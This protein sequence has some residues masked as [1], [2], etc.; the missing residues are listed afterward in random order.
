MNSGY[1]SWQ[2]AHQPTEADLSLFGEDGNMLTGADLDQAYEQLCEEKEPDV[3]L[4]E[5]LPILRADEFDAGVELSEK[6]L[7]AAEMQDL[8][9]AHM[10]R[11]AIVAEEEETKS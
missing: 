4:D 1:V 6:T 10:A 7:G 9:K 8:L 2:A 11:Y 3:V 5:L